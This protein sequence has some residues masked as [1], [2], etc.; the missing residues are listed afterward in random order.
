MRGAPV[1]SG[2]AGTPSRITNSS[3]KLFSWKRSIR[4][5]S[6]RSP[7]SGEPTLEFA[8]DRAVVA[9]LVLAQV[10]QP[11]GVVALDR[12]VD[13]FRLEDLRHT[14]RCLSLH[15]IR[16]TFSIAFTAPRSCAPFG[17]GSGLGRAS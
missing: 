5:P 1:G 15:G 12:L 8:A 17:I 2:S 3:A 11:V 6:V 9:Q 13:L 7:V 4:L 10:R 14:R 16:R